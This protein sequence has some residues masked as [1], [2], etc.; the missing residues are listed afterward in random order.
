MVLFVCAR[1]LAVAQFF[2]K[3]DR[4]NTE[5]DRINRKADRKNAELARLHTKA[6]KL[7]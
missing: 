3:V 2:V 1:E 6:D 7:F 4:L 5:L